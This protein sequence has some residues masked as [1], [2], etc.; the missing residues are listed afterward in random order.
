MA[1]MTPIFS[2][3]SAGEITPL[4]LARSDIPEIY[5]RGVGKMVN[6]RPDPRGPAVRRSGMTF[7]ASVPGYDARCFTYRSTSGRSFL[8]VVTDQQKLHVLDQDGLVLGSEQVTNPDFSDGAAGWTTVTSG[9]GSVLFTNA[10]ASLQPGNGT[11]GIEQAITIDGANDQ[12]VRIRTTD[13]NLDQEIQVTIGTASGGNDLLDMTFNGAIF[14]LS[15]PAPGVN[16]V[17]LR[18]LATSDDREID[19]VR[20]RDVTSP[21]AGIEFTT[22]WTPDDIHDIQFGVPPGGQAMF[23]VSPQQPPQQLIFDEAA[24]TWAFSPISFT[25]APP[26]WTGNNWP[27][28]ITFF[29][30]RMWLASTPDRP[31]TFWASVSGVYTDFTTGTQPDDAMEFTMA[32]QGR[33]EWM[34]GAR[35]L[36]IGTENGEH[37]VTSDG[38]VIVPGD[39][40]VEQQ[41]AF[42]SANIQADLIGI[43]ALYVSPDGRKL[44]DIGYQWAD[45]AWYSR[46]ITFPS[47]HIT[48]G[49]KITEVV[50]AQ[51]PMNLILCLTNQGELL[52]CTYETQAGGDVIGWSH[53]I[54]EGEYKSVSVAEVR[55]TSIPWAAVARVDGEIYIET[56]YPELNYVDSYIKI[57]SSTRT[58][59]VEAP[60][61]ANMEVSVVTDGAVHPNITLDDNGLGQLQWEA[62][63]IIVGLPYYSLLQTLPVDF[64]SPTGSGMAWLKSWS[65]IYVR[66]IGSARPIINGKRPP[67]R[68][69]ATPMDTEQPPATEDVKVSDLGVSPYGFITIEEDLPIPVAIGGIFGKL[70]QE[71]T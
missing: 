56:T 45:D 29:Q 1:V 44:R 60:H 24:N 27:G 66:L 69:P 42:G 9:N 25:G 17:Y 11:A 52:N 37:I 63:E 33:I 13:L 35:N 32:K 70:N 55:G 34:T 3:F 71:I 46:D 62:T 7:I 14:D 26:E 57:D 21:A 16:T 20:L 53:I 19:S 51:N 59:T 49:N 54:T 47:E 65:R 5:G 22:P 41:S 10:L 6:F 64:G 2:S 23:F 40:Q 28:V 18:V 43:K 58:T 36:L 68:D 12:R 31:E 39:I 50:Y 30:G 8:I 48:Q 61:L 67:T 4:A 15:L 38:G